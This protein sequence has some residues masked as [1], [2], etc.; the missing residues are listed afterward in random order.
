MEV[1]PGTAQQAR[2]WRTATPAGIY[3]PRRPQASP[4]YRLIDD[5]FQEFTTVYDERFSRQWGYWRHSRKKVSGKPGAIQ[6]SPPD[7]R[8]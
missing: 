2:P 5:H 4:L 6:F 7:G 3:K 1:A 8:S